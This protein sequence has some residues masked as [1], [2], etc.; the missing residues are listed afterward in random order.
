MKLESLK[1]STR[2]GRGTGA[3]RRLRAQGEILGVIYGEGKDPLP[4]TLNGKEFLKLVQY[5]GSHAL[6]E[7]D[8]SESPESN[9]PTMLKAIQ[10]HP[11]HGHVLHVDFFPL[12]LF[13][14][15]L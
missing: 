13:V 5:A 2:S 15:H 9:G 11:V 8:I 6:V 1:V 14:I 12:L 4:V 7:V 10:R 3:A